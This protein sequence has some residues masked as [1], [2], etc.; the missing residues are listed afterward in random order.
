MKFDFLHSKHDT[1]APPLGSPEQTPAEK[2]VA[3]NRN[4]AIGL[5]TLGI[6]LRSAG[7]SLAIFFVLLGTNY[8][9]Q[10]AISTENYHNLPNKKF[11]Q[12]IWLWVVLILYVISTIIS[13]P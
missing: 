1:Q 7:F 9:T 2:P 8:M 10:Y 12:R 4:L 5:L 11:Y 3:A 13:N 6:I